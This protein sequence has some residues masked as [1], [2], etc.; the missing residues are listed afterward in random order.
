[1]TR[2]DERRSRVE[3]VRGL[4]HRLVELESSRLL[5]AGGGRIAA[6]EREVAYEDVERLRD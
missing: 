3:A 6:V 5:D 1:M 2:V 4:T